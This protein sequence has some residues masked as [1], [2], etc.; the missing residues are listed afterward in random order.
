MTAHISVGPLNFTFCW[1]RCDFFNIYLLAIGPSG[2]T[3]SCISSGV[4][5]WYNFVFLY[6]FAL[7]AFYHSA[8]CLNYGCDFCG[9]VNNGV[10]PVVVLQGKLPNKLCTQNDFIIVERVSFHYEVMVTRASYLSDL[11]IFSSTLSGCFSHQSDRLTLTNRYN[12]F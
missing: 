7:C 12:H 3:T 6:T 10:G 2:C 5:G 9:H 1:D 4:L 8:F 11:D